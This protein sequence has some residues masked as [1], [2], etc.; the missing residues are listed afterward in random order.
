M[1]KDPADAAFDLVAAGKGRVM[2]I[3]H[4]MSEPDIEEA[5]RFPWTSIGSD[6]G[7][8]LVP[9]TTRCD[10]TASSPRVRKLPARHRALRARE[11][12]C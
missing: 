12:A 1:G 10:R 7:T 8:A 3:Y 4:M 11:E 2:A 5:L 6:A 9:G